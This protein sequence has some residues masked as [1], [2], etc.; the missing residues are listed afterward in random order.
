MA[1]R[2]RPIRLSHRRRQY[3]P[4]RRRT[5]SRDPRPIA[6][7]LLRDSAAN[8]AKAAPKDTAKKPVRSVSKDA[9]RKSK[10][11]A[12]PPVEP[13]PTPGIF[14]IPDRTDEFTSSVGRLFDAI[15]S[16]DWSRCSRCYLTSRQTSRGFFGLFGREGSATL[17][18]GNSEVKSAKSDGQHASGTIAF[19]VIYRDPN[20]FA[21]VQSPFKFDAAWDHENGRWVLK[22]L[23]SP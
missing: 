4:R 6:A 3:L 9:G 1:R 11:S 16:K 23:K 18:I 8:Q 20:S 15:R 13:A 14:V 12:A 2:P 5:R 17:T 19:K 7:E 21:P 10:L 22:S